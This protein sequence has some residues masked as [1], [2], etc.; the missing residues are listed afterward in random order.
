VKKVTVTGSSIKGVAA[1]SASP[2]TIIKTEDLLNQ[3]VTN[4]EEAL[5]KVSANQAGYS[6][7]QNVG[8]SSTPGSA[9]NLRGLGTDKT[10]VLLNGRRLANSPFGTASTN[11]NI[12]PL[13]MIERIEVLR[14]G[15]SA[16]YG[17]DAI[18]G[19]INFITK[20]QYEGFSISGELLQPEHSGGDEQQA[21]IFGGYGDLDEQGF[22]VFGVVDYHRTNDIFA[23]DRKVSRRG[24]NMPELG[25]FLSQ[26]SS[27][28][29][30]ANFT[31]GFML[32]NPYLNENCNNMPNVSPQGAICRTNTQAL[33]GITPKIETTSALARGTLKLTDTFNAVGEYVF[34]RN[35]VTTSVAP[36]PYSNLPTLPSTSPFYP[37]A[38]ITPGVD[39]I[40]DQELTLYLR[41][42]SGNRVSKSENDSHRAFVGIEGEAYGWDIDAG[43]TYAKSKGTDSFV[44][45]YTNGEKIQEALNNGTLNPFGPQE[46]SNLWKS[47]DVAGKTNEADLKSITYDFTVSRSLFS[48]PAGD[49]G[50]AFGA[51][52]TDQDWN[53]KTYGDVASLVSSS[54]IDPDQEPVSG[55]RQITAAFTEFHVPLLE[56]LELQLA[57]RYDDYND[58]G[59]TFN[60][61]VALRWE[62]LKELMFRTSYS[63]GFRAPTL[64]TLYETP[65]VTYTA[66]SN[67]SDPKLCPGGAPSSPQYQTECN[68]QFMIQYGGNP[69]LEAEESKSFTAGFVYEPIKNLVFTADYFNIEVENLVSTL[70]EASIFN[71]PEKYSDRFVRDSNG[72]LD[73]VNAS[74]INSGGLKTQGIDLSLNYLTPVTAGG[75][76]GF[77]IDGTYVIDLKYQEEKGQPWENLVGQYQDPA[78][79][80][81]KHVANLNWSYEAWK[82][83]FEQEFVR[84]YHDQNM[85]GREGFDNHKVPDYTLYNFSTTYTGFKNLS[86]TG[87]IKNMFDEDPSASNVVDNFQMGY[88]P[89]YGD[90][91][92]RTY[93]VRGTYK[94]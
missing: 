55:E 35:E 67:Y 41:S 16:I 77:G 92:G 30:V 69:D 90:P 25:S 60:P 51:S 49:L 28:S 75:R 42:Q 3:G 63:T 19:V 38:G 5:S 65:Y 79:V 10:L 58:F 85:T 57:A 84:G 88:D 59:D 40:T 31:D 54:G 37:G 22:N 27:L 2:I 81:W 9:A 87:G 80:R 32:G 53:S 64:A 14:D 13:A 4:V 12:I 47:F 15:A 17:A 62:P 61:K 50:F 11:L 21:S 24:I 86:L 71:E 34:S 8:A 18:A 82:M 93:F 33:I 29:S 26:G 70:G 45:G 83:V 46:D 89:R 94:F 1:Q 56:N 43:I 44:S 48:L 74:Y 68:K 91:T 72:L 6:T 7:A 20:E 39:G 36:D 23:K 76:F 78:V 66:G 52:Y 73:Y